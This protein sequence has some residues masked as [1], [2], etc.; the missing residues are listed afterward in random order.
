MIQ[1]M[2]E[3]GNMDYNKEYNDVLIRKD[4]FAHSN[5]Y[6]TLDREWGELYG[7]NLAPPYSEEEII[8]SE[9]II[10]VRLPDILRNYLLY[11]SREIFYTQYP[12][13]CELP[14]EDIGSAHSICYR[15]YYKLSDYIDLKGIICVGENA[16]AKIYMIIKG[17]NRGLYWGVYNNNKKCKFEPS[18]ILGITIVC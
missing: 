18:F 14:T 7:Y 12:V 8:Q 4:A 15:D 1:N 11:V 16:Y 13:I 6:N 3:N 9:K 2:D 5:I 17:R 10:K